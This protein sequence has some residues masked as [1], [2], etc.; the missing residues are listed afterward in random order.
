MT[1]VARDGLR[2]LAGSRAGSAAATTLERIMPARR[3]HL[4][5]L[6]FHRVTR[7]EAEVVPGL[8]SATPDGFTELL[9]ALMDRHTIVGLDAVLRRLDGGPAL[10]RRALLL[11][12]DDAYVDMMVHAWPVLRE[13]RLPAV[14][15]VP[16]AYPDAADRVFWWEALHHAIATTHAPAVDGPAGPLP[17]TGGAERQRAYRSLRDTFKQLPHTELIERLARLE[18]EL[19]V[20]RP[21]STVA[22]WRELRAAASD[23]L[24]LAPHSRTHPLLTK[25]DRA[26]VDDEVSG[27]RADL[28]EATGLDVPA[29]AYPAGAVSR[30][31]ADAVMRAGLRVAFT[32]VRGVNDMRTADPMLLRRVNVS[33]RTPAPAI[34]ALLLR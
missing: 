3:D 24:I 4:A 12:F 10:P 27:S 5:V 9:D 21:A 16:T 7:P 33:V 1:D 20:A 8:L 13:R 23:G 28:L 22:S 11:T 34:R 18:A 30:P 6:T 17:L 29:F 19:D 2:W 32:T 25:V 26:A 15:F 14:L 31:V